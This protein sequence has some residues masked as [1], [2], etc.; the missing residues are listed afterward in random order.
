MTTRRKD[1]SELV[2]YRSRITKL[3]RRRRLAG[4]SHAKL[5]GLEG[6]SNNLR[7]FAVHR[8]RRTTKF[9]PGHIDLESVRGR[10]GARGQQQQDLHLG[11]VD[12]IIDEGEI[13]QHRRDLASYVGPA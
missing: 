3:D 5:E 7:R 2:S 4:R 8:H 9:N 13:F 12:E 10:P 6:H 1:C 11:L